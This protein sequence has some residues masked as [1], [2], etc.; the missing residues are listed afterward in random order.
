MPL[1]MLAITRLP[2]PTLM[3]IGA[4]GALIIISWSYS[5]WR[6]A[7]KLAFVILLFEGALRKWVFPSGQELV[8]FMKDV[9]LFG[10]YL[11]FFLAPDSD[12]RAYRLNASGTLIALL[13]ALV[14]MTALNPN[15]GSGLLALY[16][17][18]IYLFYV[19]LAFMMPYLFRSNEEMVRQLT[20]YALLAIPICLLGVVQYGAGANSWL[21]VYSQ[22]EA[23]QETGAAGFGFG[24]R[25]RITGTFSYLSG[26]TTF[27]IF[28][29]MLQLTLLS[30]KETRWKWIYIGISLPLLM[31][32]AFMGGSR[33]SVVTLGLL[34]A[35]YA[36]ASMTGKIKSDR[37]FTATLIAVGLICFVGAVYFFSDAWMNISRRFET[38]GDTVH[39]RTIDMPLK[40]M[41]RALD[42]SGLTG[43][44]IG[45]GHPATFAL[46]RVLQIP[47][48]R[49][50]AP[51]FDNELGQVLVELGLFGFTAWYALRLVFLV[52]VWKSFSKEGIS[53]PVKA[54]SLGAVLLV[55]PHLVMSVVL[56]HTANMFLF[57]LTGL[58]LIPR[59]Q[60]L[61]ARQHVPRPEI[62]TQPKVM[63][64]K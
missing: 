34:V 8:Y 15:I 56:N 45:L 3:A 62:P 60:P 33:S 27:V 32:N 54:L 22:Q 24:E 18:K 53:G 5:N 43:L 41:G 10:A 64:S 55:G 30:L 11:R 63:G 37:N 14:A 38:A 49:I 39:S 52:M 58:A 26:H 42:T 21:N 19:P 46:R 36:V 1:S 13:C 25:V 17:I 9:F 23:M 47:L 2:L 6:R 61:L 44:G 59:K 4:I 40:A 28:F 51:V 57:G 35:G 12:I 20:W 48:P 29:G 7:V 50:Q 16:G 31:G